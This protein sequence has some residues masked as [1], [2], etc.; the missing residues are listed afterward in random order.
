MANRAI[1]QLLDRVRG[2]DELARDSLFALAYEELRRLARSRLREGG[3]NTMLC[4]TDLV[5]D[6]YLRLMRGGEL[7][8]EDRRAFFGYASRVMRSV[9]VDSAREA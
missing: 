2:G 1:T 5:H 9:I 6:S 7:R 3:R 4:T 8:A